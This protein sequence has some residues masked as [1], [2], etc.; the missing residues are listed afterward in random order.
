MMIP[1]NTFIVPVA[2]F[3]VFA[4]GTGGALA[5]EDYPADMMAV[6]ATPT[7]PLGPYT[8]DCDVA[9]G[10]LECTDV[11]SGLSCK[12]IALDTNDDGS[13]LR[14]VE[15]SMTFCNGSEDVF[16]VFQVSM[17]FYKDEVQ[18]EFMFV[19]DPGFV[20][21]RQLGCAEITLYAGT[22]D[23]CSGGLYQVFAYY[24]AI[25]PCPNPSGECPEPDNHC[26]SER[27]VLFFIGKQ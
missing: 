5:S 6:M 19:R 23:V 26:S 20:P 1:T 2:L 7:N 8:L 9:G 17:G 13:C 22:V 11:E 27:D 16:H 18:V 12:N 21:P 10:E 15:Y 3:L 4:V 25:G 14:D 24:E